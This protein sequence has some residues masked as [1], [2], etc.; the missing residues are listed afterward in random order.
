MAGFGCST[1]AAW[2]IL[3]TVSQRS[4]TKLRAVADCLVE[5]SQPGGEMLQD[6]QQHLSAAVQNSRNKP[7]RS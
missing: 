4:D 6:L 1:E 5:A 2:E 7:R 3:V